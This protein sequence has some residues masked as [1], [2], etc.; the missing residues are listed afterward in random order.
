MRILNPV[1]LLFMLGILSCKN[2]L[3]EQR[4]YTAAKWENPEIFEIIRKTTG[5]FIL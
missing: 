3:V 2:E 5:S 4:I 1:W